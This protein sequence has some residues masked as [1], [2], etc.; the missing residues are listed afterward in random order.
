MEMV[1]VLAIIC[2]LG[3]IIGGLCLAI[4]NS[5]ITTYNI[6][7]SSDYA[8]L[9]ARG[10]ENSFLSKSQKPTGAANQVCTWYV[11]NN[12]SDYPTLRVKE[13]SSDTAVFEPQF[14]GSN[15]DG[16][17]KWDIYMFYKWD[18][19]SERVLYCLFLKD[20]K[21][22]TDFAYFYQGGFWVPRFTD[23]KVYT[24]ADSRNIICGG[25]EMGNFLS[26]QSI[27]TN[28]IPSN[29]LSEGYMTNISYTH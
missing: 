14:L 3:G 20:N 6:D 16:N 1:L 2:L 5:F 19:D 17:Y 21:N 27:S 4:S 13:G 9:F 10:F 23:R 24:G 11:R 15:S 7:D 12:G 29:V 22:G 18:P 28:Q 25:Q 8:L 26:A